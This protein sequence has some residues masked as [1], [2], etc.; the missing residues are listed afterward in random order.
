MEVIAGIIIL[1]IIVV[2]IMLVRSSARR[3]R[4]SKIL[5]QRRGSV[6]GSFRNPPLPE[7]WKKELQEMAQRGE[8]H[9]LS[10][11]EPD[12]KDT[13][14]RRTL[15]AHGHDIHDGPQLWQVKPKR[16][17][18]RSFKQLR[19]LVKRQ[20]SRGSQIRNMTSTETKAWTTGALASFCSTTRVLRKPDAEH[21][22]N[23][24]QGCEQLE[25][26]PSGYGATPET[27]WGSNPSLASSNLA[28]SSESEPDRRAPE[29]EADPRV[30]GSCPPLSASYTHTYYG[31]QGRH[32]GSGNV[33]PPDPRQPVLKTGAGFSSRGFDSSAF[34]K[35]VRHPKM[36][37]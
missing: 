3:F 17:K 22:L 33:Q 14:A 15:E 10:G 7:D 16:R 37:K 35:I 1:A 34:R 30:R 6:N 21:D 26:S 31:I 2:Y 25:R 13:R 12:P 24:N 27:W 9:S 4:K 19:N 32:I 20:S 5:I 23:G 11:H 29:S 36:R 28:R 18:K 8:I